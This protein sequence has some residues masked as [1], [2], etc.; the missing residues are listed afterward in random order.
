MS[1]LAFALGICVVGAMTYAVVRM[2][3]SRRR[4]AKR[5]QIFE[6]ITTRAGEIV[7]C[8]PSAVAVRSREGVSILHPLAVEAR[9]ADL[10]CGQRVVVCLYRGTVVHVMPVL[11]EA[12]PERDE[13][14]KRT[15]MKFANRLIAENR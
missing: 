11:R 14:V 8:T 5:Q 2:E 6:E 3:T 9:P 7:E 10:Q 12:S 4:W 15:F 13:E 1:T